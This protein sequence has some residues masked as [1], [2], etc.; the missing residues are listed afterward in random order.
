[1]NAR[2]L[3]ALLKDDTELYKQYTQNES[4]KK[5][6]ADTIFEVTYRGPDTE[7]ET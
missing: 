3:L 7:D 6:L 2:V 5:W 4:F 1:M